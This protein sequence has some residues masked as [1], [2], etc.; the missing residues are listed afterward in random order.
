[1]SVIASVPLSLVIVSHFFFFRC[2]RNDCGI[3]LAGG[4]GGGGGGG[5]K[6]FLAKNNPGPSF[7]QNS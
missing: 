5:G 3:F 4:G 7:A 6:I 1:M 2:L